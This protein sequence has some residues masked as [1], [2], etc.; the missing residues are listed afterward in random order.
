MW[1]GNSVLFEVGMCVM[2]YLTVLY[3]E[4]LPIVVE[5]FKGRVNLPG[6]LRAFNRLVGSVCSTLVDK[7]SRAVHLRSSSSRASCSPAC[8]SRRSG[9]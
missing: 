9:R 4:F 2:V 3:I 8:T 6:P 7:T 1:Q 5:R